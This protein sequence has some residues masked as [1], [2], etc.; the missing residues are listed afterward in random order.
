[1]IERIRVLIVLSLK[2]MHKQ[3]RLALVLAC[4]VVFATTYVLILPAFTLEAGKAADQ[5]GIDVPKA[6]LAVD[7]KADSD[8]PGGTSS[9]EK[10]KALS[11]AKGDSAKAKTDTEGTGKVDASAGNSGAANN[12]SGAGNSGAANNTDNAGSSINSGAENSNAGNSDAEKSK[13]DLENGEGADGN[14]AG[15]DAAGSSDSAGNSTGDDS[16]GNTDNPD[17]DNPD[18][19]EGEN[20]EASDEGA[21]ATEDSDAADSKDQPHVLTAD[22]KDYTVTVEYGD[23]AEL[24][25]GVTLEADEIAP[26]TKAYKECIAKAMEAVNPTEEVSIEFARFFDIRLMYEGEK[27]EPAAPVKVSVSYK[28]ALEL[29]DENELLAV[30]FADKGPEVIDAETDKSNKEVTFV[31]DSFSIT[32]T[33]VTTGNNWPSSNGPYIMYVQQGNDY[34]AVAHDRTLTPVTISNNQVTFDSHHPINKEDYLWQYESQ[35]YSTPWGQRYRYYV[36]YKDGSGDTYLDPDTDTGISSDATDLTRNGSGRIAINYGY[37][38]GPYIG[39]QDGAIV[40]NK[41]QT[42]GVQIQFAQIPRNLTIHFVDRYGNPI[43]GVKYTGSESLPVTEN[44]DGTFY[45]PY[46]WGGQNGSI[47]ISTMF[48][49]SGYTYAS[50][51]LAGTRDGTSMTYDGLTIDHV[52]TERNRNLY[53]KSDCG[54]QY[55]NPR[56]NLGYQALPDYNFNL[57]MSVP[58]EAGRS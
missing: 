47:D 32:G 14:S 29:T 11:E 33:I 1:M 55:A 3:K 24:P 21:D 34:Y 5:G 23:D 41:Q 2:K 53:Y 38:T 13:L 15:D 37:S 18:G 56:G 49:K 42:D 40:G 44:A 22:G 39:V 52:L 30:H 46:D 7:D 20:A 43:E 12:S 35:G 54:D 16:A 45:V 36:Y 50:T 48:S 25:E 51:H 9:G 26:D 28:E 17:A 58:K 19:S 8:D 57:A 4:L 27:Y 6:L 31:Q 10:S